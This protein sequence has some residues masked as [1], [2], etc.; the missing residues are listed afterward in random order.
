MSYY[1]DQHKKRME[2]SK[3]ANQAAVDA[4]SR[5]LQQL[6][7]DR[8]V[9]Q[10]AKMIRDDQPEGIAAAE[11]MTIVQ[12]CL[13]RGGFVN[14]GAAV[15]E[16]WTLQY[17]PV[18]ADR[19]QPYVPSDVT[20][21]RSQFSDIPGTPA[22]LTFS[23]ALIERGIRFIRSDRTINLWRV[24]GWLRDVKELKGVS[25]ITSGIG[26]QFVLACYRASFPNISF[27]VNIR[28]VDAWPDF[29]IRAIQEARH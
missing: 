27:E 5:A 28:T 22:S 14:L 10:A 12:E 26:N 6:Q 29:A 7:L 11:V 17:R 24:C 15:A 4:S 8:S 19:A 1:L 9:T 2:E 16:G 21:D 20:I 13:A 25:D 18:N 23:A 3:R